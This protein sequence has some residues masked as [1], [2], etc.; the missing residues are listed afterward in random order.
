MR[1]PYALYSDSTD[2]TSMNLSPPGS[3]IVSFVTRPI[4]SR[5]NTMRASPL[6]AVVISPFLS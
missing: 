4:G 1:S 2:M 5:S 6:S 3:P